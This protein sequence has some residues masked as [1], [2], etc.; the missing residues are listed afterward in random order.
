M[1]VRNFNS[2]LDKPNL[3]SGGTISTSGS[4]VI[5]EYNPS[6]YRNIATYNVIFKDDPDERK[7]FNKQIRDFYIEQMKSDAKKDEETY[8]SQKRFGFAIFII[9]IIL[10]L[11]G[12]GFSI[13]QLFNAINYGDYSQLTTSIEIQKAGNLVL[14]TSLVGAFVLIVSLV[15]FF[16]FLQFVYKP[17]SKRKDFFENI[18]DLSHL[19]E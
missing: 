17:N 9:V 2:E 13:V 16:L 7:E 14:T 11:A 4:A 10:V 1:V 15:F 19:M 8:I 12:I 3:Y 5:P 18:K 6:V